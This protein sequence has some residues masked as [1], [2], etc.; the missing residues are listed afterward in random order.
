MIYH[1]RRLVAVTTDLRTLAPLDKGL[2]RDLNML[3]SQP[4]RTAFD[5]AVLRAVHQIV[6][7]PKVFDDPLAAR[8]LGSDGG[9]ALK[10][11]V[12]DAA[13]S[14]RL[15]AMIV[16]RSRIAEDALTEAINR[17]ARQ[18]VVLGAGLDT[19]VYRNTGPKVH[20]FEVDHPA[21]QAWKRE[22]L[23]AAGLDQP[24]SLNFVPI[25]FERQSLRKELE[26]AG[27]RFDRPAVFTLLGVIPYVERL[28]V[29]A[30]LG[31]IAS[32]RSGNAEVVFDYAEPFADASPL[33]RSAYE[34][35]TMRAAAIGEPWVT[36]FKPD[37]LKRELRSLGFDQIDD[38][39]TRALNGRYFA[40]R[41]DNF[42]AAPLVHV[43]RARN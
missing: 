5:V 15:R 23:D 38:M 10:L 39:D 6:D 24:E 13:K 29:L 20:V 7:S 2:S 17:G 32:S 25:D 3:E 27:F 8:I 4:S 12:D 1:L 42:A 9:N 33:V 30:T 19:F 41:T 36:F 26:R 16:V 18:Y 34:A 21:T 31:L 14:A 22:R 35:I 40:G 11:A 28:A 43:V 37:E